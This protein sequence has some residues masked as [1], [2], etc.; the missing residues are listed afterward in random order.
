MESKLNASE[1]SRETYLFIYL[2]IYISLTYLIPPSPSP[3]VPFPLGQLLFCFPSKNKTKQN[4]K[5]K[6]KIQTSKQTNKLEDSQGSQLYMA[7]K[8]TVKLGTKPLIISA[9]GNPV[10]GK[11]SQVKK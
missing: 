7:Q 2:F 6:N 1:K 4:K 3:S 8:V 5:N 10:G 9:Q 11:G